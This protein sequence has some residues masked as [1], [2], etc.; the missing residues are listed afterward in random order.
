MVRAFFDLVG[1]GVLRPTAQQ[2]A[3]RAGVGIRTVFRHFSEMDSLFAEVDAL[4]REQIGPYLVDRPS[5]GTVAERA[6]AIVHSRSAAFE[7]FAPY[8]RATRLYRSRSDFLSR[9]F[10]TFVRRQRAALLEALPELAAAPQPLVDALELATSFESW[11][12]L[13]TD[14]RL[15]A[16]RTRA[17][18]EET[19]LALVSRLP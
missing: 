8:L 4:L 2:V 1:E 3:E 18:L 16:A 13:R 6:V 19:V 12:R 11:D 9:S 15:G 5:G 17:A 10:A 14:Q 7:R